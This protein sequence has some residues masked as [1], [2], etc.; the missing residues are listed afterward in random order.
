MKQYR[1]YRESNL[2]SNNQEIEAIFITSFKDM[3]NAIKR[4]KKII[5]ED[6]DDLADEHYYISLYENK[7]SIW[8]LNKDF[9]KKHLGSK[10]AKG[11]FK[12]LDEL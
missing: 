6:D 8:Q 11:I 4:L 5:K 9:G 12:Q 7:E 2:N 1:I 3:A 10:T